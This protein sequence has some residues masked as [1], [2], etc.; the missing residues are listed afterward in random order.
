MEHV[1]D[2]L[3]AHVGNLD[4]DVIGVGC[5][6]GFQAGPLA[7]GETFLPGAKDVTDAVER[8]ARAAAQAQVATGLAARQSREVAS[9]L[10]LFGLT[11]RGPGELL[12]V[13]PQCISQLV[14]SWPA[15][16]A[17]EQGERK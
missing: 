5:E 1:A 15:D 14:N 4:R 7:R 6:C 9:Q 13:S 11:V 17:L 16:V 2:V 3:C 10:R 8:V 12:R